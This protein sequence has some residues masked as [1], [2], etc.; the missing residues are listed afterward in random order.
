MS[1]TR[2]C[3]DLTYLPCISDRQA[4]Q[5]TDGHVHDLLSSQPFYHLRL[6]HVHVGAMAQPEVVPLPPA[7]R[8]K[9]SSILIYGYG[10]AM[11]QRKTLHHSTGASSIIA[12][13]TMP[14]VFEIML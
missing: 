14:K 12:S 13:H 5:G 11:P 1:D 10:L 2:T 3:H 8:S 6:P 9:V 4:V 7:G